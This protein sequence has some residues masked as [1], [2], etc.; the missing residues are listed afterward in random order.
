MSE[1]QKR[2]EESARS[3]TGSAPYKV[4]GV[5]RATGAYGDISENDMQA[6]IDAGATEKDFD[7]IGGI[8]GVSAATG[9]EGDI[10]EFNFDPDRPELSAVVRQVIAKAWKRAYLRGQNYP[11]IQIEQ[12]MGGD[13]GRGDQQKGTYYTGKHGDPR[14]LYGESE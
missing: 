13:M 4:F 9:Q 5:Q 8:L 6:L 2:T 14:R 7:A 3:I 1:K 11:E 10:S 12:M